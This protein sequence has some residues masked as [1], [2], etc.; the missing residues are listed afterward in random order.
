[1][2]LC[3]SANSV[4]LSAGN[5]HYN[6]LY[7]TSVFPNLKGQAWPQ[8]ARCVVEQGAKRRALTNVSSV[9]VSPSQG[10]VAAESA[11]QEGSAARHFRVGRARECLESL[12]SQL[13]VCKNSPMWPFEVITSHNYQR[14]LVSVQLINDFVSSLK[15]FLAVIGRDGNLDF[16]DLCLIDY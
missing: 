2:V 9:P 5:C 6:Y 8:E 3:I 4:K 15:L 7:N 11:G 16:I 14:R 10:S 1:M 13:A 12:V